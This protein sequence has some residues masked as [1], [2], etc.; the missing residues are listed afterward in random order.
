MEAA[1]MSKQDALIELMHAH[2]RGVW[3]YLRFLGADAALADDLTQETF[4]AAFEKPFDDLGPS[5]TAAYLRTA[6]RHLFLNV[7]RREKRNLPLGAIE[8]AEQ[9]WNLLTPQG[10]SDQRLELLRKCLESLPQRGR[11]AIDLEYRD[12]RSGAEIALALESSEDAVKALL[13]RARGELRDC[14]EQKMRREP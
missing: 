5:A 13:K 6:A 7:L 8:E 1:T 2:Q 9:A 14:I 4:I 10:D 12:G 11:R 3:R